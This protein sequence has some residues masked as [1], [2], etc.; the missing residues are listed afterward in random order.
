MMGL[1]ALY[2]QFTCL[3]VAR[4]QAKADELDL[5]A[6]RLSDGQESLAQA[7]ATIKK[8]LEALGYGE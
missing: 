7:G 4:R 8:N 3:C 6:A 2:A 5:P 1:A